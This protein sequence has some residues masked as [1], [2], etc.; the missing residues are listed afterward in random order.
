MKDYAYGIFYI[1][2]Q[3]QKGLSAVLHL[4][5]PATD[6]TPV[7]LYFILA[8]FNTDYHLESNK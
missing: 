5:C 1:V 4:C 7:I 2:S 8:I 6:V 3:R